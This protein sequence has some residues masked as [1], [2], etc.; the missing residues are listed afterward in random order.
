MSSRRNLDLTTD[1][2]DRFT[3]AFKSEKF[4]NLFIE[5]CNEISDPENRRIYEAELKQLEAERGIDVQFI[6]PEPGF[7]IKSIANG[8][9]KIFINVAKCDSIEKPTSQCGFD[10]KTGEKGLHWSLPY[11]QSKPKHDFDKNKVICAVFDVIFHPDTL[12]LAKKNQ[13]F[14]KLVIETAYDAVRT[15][16]DLTLDS[17]KNLKFPKLNYKGSSTPVVIRKRSVP[18]NGYR[19]S[20][21]G[22]QNCQN[23]DDNHDDQRQPMATV[24]IDEYTTPEYEII[25]RRHIEMHEFTEELD[26]KLNITVPKELIIKI[27]LPLLDSSKDV[28]LD[29]N[30]KSIYMQCDTPAK[31]KLTISLPFDVD[32]ELGKAQ[33]DNQTKILA[34]TL[35]VL[36]TRKQLGILD[37]CR[38]DSG[39]ESDHHSPKE[40]SS[41]GLDDDVFT[42]DSNHYSLESDLISSIGS[43]SVT[44]KEQN[45]KV[46][47]GDSFLESSINYTL[48]HFTYNRFEN[49]VAFTL[50]VKNVESNSIVYIGTKN[51]YRVKFS[52][53]GSGYFNNYYAFY[54]AIPNGM[55]IISESPRI[56]TWDNNVVI[57]IELNA[58]EHFTSYEVGLSA[59]DCKTVIC[60]EKKS[61]SDNNEKNHGTV[62]TSFVEVGTAM[63]NEELRIE[64]TNKY[65][66]AKSTT[67]DDEE[68]DEAI[69]VPIHRPKPKKTKRENKKVRSLSE[70]HCDELKH[71]EEATAKIAD[72][73]NKAC[74]KHD[75]KSRTQSESSN[76]EHHMDL[77]P[78]KSILKRHSSYDRTTTPECSLDE[79]G[80]ATSIDLGIGSSIPEENDVEKSESVKK[81]V[82]FDKQLCRKLLFKI[83]S[84]IIGQRKPKENK[85]KKKKR[86]QERRYS[87]GEASDYENN[88]QMGPSRCQKSSAPIDVIKNKDTENKTNLIFDIEI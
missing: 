56:E 2:R 26:A 77:F 85:R 52:T 28:V 73:A 78:L 35:P 80:C 21:I 49:V 51:S 71:T 9:Q 38:E 65:F 17:I 40:D 32:K 83:N 5:Y 36:T 68:D 63:S 87:E 64:I 67:D 54:F 18:E 46:K 11:V 82:R 57:Q 29:V 48:P 6:S 53:V 43:S 25:H 23:I 75:L 30:I 8:N 1:E 20:F 70:S 10:V 22:K 14:R 15:T 60:N 81:T 33:F 16:F 86:N 58:I 24:T 47:E 50:H 88:L 59:G 74:L 31:Y 12:H 72:D 69:K 45:T 42:D 66:K 37:L 27:H 61:N 62:K 7:V 76:D 55:A 79:Y 34:L 3:K 84:T 39:V 13:A 4:R 41:L 44:E 19:K